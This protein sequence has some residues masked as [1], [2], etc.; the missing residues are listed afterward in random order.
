DT[1]AEFYEQ[2]PAMDPPSKST[3]SI[4]D[5]DNYLL[6]LSK[7][8]KENDQERLLHEIT[9]KCTSNDLKMFIRLTQKDLKI[10]AGPKQI[11][12]ALDIN[13]YDAYQHSNNLK[14][15][16]DRYLQHK[17]SG[18][19]TKLSLA[20]AFSVQI[21]LMTP[22]HPM[23]AEACKSV[24][25]AFK[26]CKNTILAEIKY[27]GERL[28]L[29][30]NKNKFEFFSRNL[31][32]VQQ[33]KVQDLN[34]YITEAFP[35]ADDLILDGEILLIDIKTKK[36]LPFGTLG[37]HKK[38]K[39]SEANIAF[40]VFDCLYFN[41]E[42]LLDLPLK[43]RRTILTKHMSPIEN[44]ILI[45]EQK[46][47]TKK[48]EL[49]TLINYAI[50]EGLEGL[51][52]K[53]PES[54]YEPGKR[55]WLK[56]KKDYLLEG[57]MAD[58]CD[59]VVLGAYYGTGKKGGLMSVFLLGCYDQTKQQWCTVCKCGNGFDDAKID[60][61]QKELK[62]NLIKISKDMK[63]VPNWLNLNRQYAPD[64]VVVDPKKSPVWEI[65]VSN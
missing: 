61:L 34:K 12:D 27:D 31:K 10:N 51:V 19:P 62:P 46:L 4:Y 52:L 65:T 47:V 48:S 11:L 50:S 22:V 21:E 17:S 5:I 25:Y 15:F 59:L 1:V 44:R 2:S 16:V 60:Q 49:Q 35:K 33:H 41:G 45:S 29:H 43:E 20:K 56:V 7:L 32:S 37:V 3:L 39:Y 30:K 57:A 24:D 64:F 53:D 42:S 18:S 40:F 13:A 58:T 38:A 14:T 54:L 26:K 8:T 9:I 63:K 23:L 55:H 36:P 6:K 28:Q